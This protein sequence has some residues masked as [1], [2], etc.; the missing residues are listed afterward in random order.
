MTAARSRTGS[1][2]R[3]VREARISALLPAGA[4][5]RLEASGVVA[6]DGRYHVIFD[7]LRAVALIDADL[8]RTAG[9]ALVPTE[10]GRAPGYEDIA[11]D[12]VTGHVFLLIEA[13]DRDGGLQA[14]VEEYDRALRFVSAGWL[15]YR[16]PRP[17]KGME[18]LEVVRRADGVYLLALHEVGGLLVFRQGRRN[19]NHV[20]TAQL[21]AGLH[22]ADYS[23]VSLA[24]GRLAMVSQ[25]SSALWAG[26]FSTGTWAAVGPGDTYLFPREP[27]GEFAYRTIEGVCWLGPDRVVVVSDRGKRDEEG[28]RDRA[29]EE[30]LHV[31]D[32]PPRPS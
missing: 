8:D 6:A 13:Q 9:T 31:F 14:R 22:F 2:L 16:L 20:A 3:L 1:A 25:E 5:E 23:A 7:N 29:R 26:E 21:P 28:R 10:P 27:G 11:R 32:L 19:W 17:N 30:S 12:P 15:E 18:G 4:P 24:G